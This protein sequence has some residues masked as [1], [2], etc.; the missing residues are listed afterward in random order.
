MLRL[1]GLLVGGMVGLAFMVACGSSDD[2]GDDGGSGGSGAGNGGGVGADTGIPEEWPT[3][4]NVDP[5]EGGVVS[6]TDDQVDQI[7]A[8]GCTGWEAEPESVPALLMIL[9]DTSLSMDSAAPN[10]RESKWSITAAALN[11]AIDAMPPSTPLGL[12]FYP[13]RGIYSESTPQDLTACVDVS[14]LI[15]VGPNQQDELHAAIA[16]VRPDGCTPTH[17]AYQY[18]LENGLRGTNYPGAP[19]IVLITDGQPTLTI[20]CMGACSP[21]NPVP[22]QPISDAI[23]AAYEQDGT[24][25]FVIGS[26]GSEQ[27]ETTGEDVRAWL[28]HAAID[29]GTATLDCDPDGPNFCHFDMS[30]EE[31]F[32]VGLRSA[33]AEITGAVISCSYSIPT[34]PAGESVDLD[35]VNLI[36]HPGEGGNVLLLQADSSD[37]REGWYFDADNN[38][39]LCSDS[40][41]RLQSDNMASMSLV[42]GC[43]TFVEPPQ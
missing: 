37:C 34:A 18:A 22:T 32:S 14:S 24:H 16:A 11:E 9:V 7:E 20:D 21:A 33:L 42:F 13:N 6:L 25:T 28:S 12:M 23:R 30:V 43:D 19:Y 39:A 4:E 3:T 35:A 38:V 26:P 10:S 8:D 41:A 29:G 40:C 1:R 36:V 2:E 5:G 27:N 15:P 17:G 31:D